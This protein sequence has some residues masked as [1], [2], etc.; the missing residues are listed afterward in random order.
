MAVLTR[1]EFQDCLTHG[2]DERLDISD[3]LVELPRL[4][5]FPEGSGVRYIRL[6]NKQYNY[7]N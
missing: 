7:K 4:L 5:V 3:A 6:N 2:W 1:E